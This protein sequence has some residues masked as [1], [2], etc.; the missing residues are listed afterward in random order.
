VRATSIIVA[1]RLNVRDVETHCK[2]NFKTASVSVFGQI[3]DDKP[4]L[5]NFCHEIVH[6]VAV[7]IPII[8]STTAIVA[9]FDPRY[10]AI[11]K[12]IRHRRVK[13]PTKPSLDFDVRSGHTLRVAAL[14]AIDWP[15]SAAVP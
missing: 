2:S 10:A 7:K 1:A 8:Y 6:H 12:G 14:P 11:C 3:D 9:V 13:L 5:P 4:R 15:P